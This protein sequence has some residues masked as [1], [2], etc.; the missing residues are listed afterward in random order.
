VSGEELAKIGHGAEVLEFKEPGGMMDHYT[1]TL[2]GLLYIDCGDP[3]KPTPIP[4]RL[5][6]FVL[7]NSLEK[8]N[9][10]GVLSSAKEATRRGVEA[11]T[12]ELAGFALRTT[13]FDD[14]VS[15]LRKLPDPSA[16]MIYAQLINR[17]I[18][19]RAAVLLEEGLYDQ[20]VLGEMLDDHH[21]MLRDHLGISTPKIEAMIGAAKSAGAL[22]CKIN[23]SGGG[24]TMI[25]YAPGCQKDVAK[26]IEGA[27]G[28]AYVI[29]KAEGIRLEVG[30]LRRQDSA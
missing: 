24:G 28:V 2:G 16:R 30:V 22:G 4:T 26:A 3:V 15:H 20:D 13:A 7:G 18:C 12:R 29:K 17:D 25:A 27:G 9:T 21:E 19:Q 10:K 1:C 6:G 23:G 14:A 8:K 11:L 5:D